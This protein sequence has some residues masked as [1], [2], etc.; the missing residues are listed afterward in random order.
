MK[1][2]KEG[3]TIPYFSLPDQDGNMVNI[4]DYL[5]KRQ[6]VIFFYPQDG[7]LSCTREACYFRDLMDV[8]E[9]ADAEII[10]ISGQSVESHKNFATANN[11]KYRLLA[12]TRDEVRKLFGVPSTMF[13]LIPGRV[14]YVTDRDG[15]VVFVFN[16]QTEI[17]RHADEALKICLLL[18]KNYRG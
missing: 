6:L 13:G 7:S 10:G 1:P 16:S 11:L 14:T 8:F 3:D 2:I 5:G 17:Q 12:D 9:E 18:K 15:K 4:S